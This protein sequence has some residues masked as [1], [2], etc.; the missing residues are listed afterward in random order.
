MSSGP[1]SNPSPTPGVNVYDED[2]NVQRPMDG[3]A[4][5]AAH[6]AFLAGRGH[7]TPDHNAGKGTASEHALPDLRAQKRHPQTGQFTK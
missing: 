5:A 7:T 2:P 6:R 3:S 4:G 1:L